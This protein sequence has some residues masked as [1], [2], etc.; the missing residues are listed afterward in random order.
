MEWIV[1]GG[2]VF[3]A[4]VLKPKR[5]LKALDRISVFACVVFFAVMVAYGLASVLSLW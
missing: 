4:Y 3:L 1:I 2:V 5:T